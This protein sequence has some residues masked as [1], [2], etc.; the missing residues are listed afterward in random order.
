MIGE[1][2]GVW[3]GG[4]EWGHPPVNKD[5]QRRWFFLGGGM[6]WAEATGV[7]ALAGASAWPTVCDGSGCCPS[8]REDG[9]AGVAAA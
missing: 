7:D 2:A 4:W 5:A 1:E 8:L 6:D 3:E 9:R